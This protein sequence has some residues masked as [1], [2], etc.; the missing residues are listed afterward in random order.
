VYSLFRVNSEAKVTVADVPSAE[1]VTDSTSIPSIVI[2]L[3]PKKFKSSP[4][5][6][7]VVGLVAQT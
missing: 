5:T 1:A 3:A 7:R 6:V 2:S 4:V